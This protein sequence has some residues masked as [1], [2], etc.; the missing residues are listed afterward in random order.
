MTNS[1][2]DTQRIANNP[3]KLPDA[4][5]VHV[6]LPVPLRRLFEYRVPIDSAI[7]VKPGMRVA[8]PFS[9]SE[10][11]GIIVKVCDQPQYTLNKIKSINKV[12]DDSPLVNQS[13]IEL[14][15]WMK[16]Y[17]HAPP[18]EVWQTLLPTALLKGKLCQLKRTSVWK[19]TDEGV[20]AL[21][22][23]KVANNAVKQQQALRILCEN[24]ETGIPHDNLSNFGLSLST[25]KSI[26]GKKWSERVYSP[27]AFS[28]QN[29]PADFNINKPD[30][31]QL[32]S[33]QK[34]A[35]DSVCSAL[36]EFKTS[37]LFGV[38]ASGKTEVYLQIIEQVIKQGKQALVLVPEI[39]LTPQ[40]VERFQRRFNTPIETI[41][42]AMTEQ[43]R[44]QSW[45]KAR[46]G[47]AK[48][49]IGTRSALF[50]PLRN[51]GIIIIDEEHDSSFKQ[52]QGLRYSARDIAM[53]RGNIEKIPV[54]LG[55]ASPSIESLMNVKK[56]K[57]SELTLSKK[58]MTSHPLKYR[59][60]DLKNQPI[61]EG[62]SFALID[63]IKHHLDKQGQILL[64]LNRRGYSPVLLCHNCGW[65]SQCKR[66]D[67]HFTFHSQ[68]THLQCH[69]CGSSKRAPKQC[70]D[71]FG[72]QM[73]P[74]GLGTERLEESIKTIFPAA[75]V[76]RI[77]RDTTRQ[78]SAMQEFVTEIKSGNV[79]IL[80]G[81]QMLAKGHHFPDV[82][83]VGLIDMDGALYSSDFRAP[84]YA[85]QLITQVSGRAGRA[86]KKSEVVIQTH[87]ADHP[88]LGQLISSGYK[89]FSQSTIQQRIEAQLPPHSFNALFQAEATYLGHTKTFLQE[90]KQILQ[91]HKSTT[92]LSSVELLGP[93]PA[94]YTKKA[95]K[96]RYQLYLESNNR[97][98]LHRLLHASLPEVEKLR[99]VSRVRWRM[100][101][102]PIG[103]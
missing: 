100:E 34:I 84:E 37:L 85:A 95:G 29:L 67:T 57:I 13:I 9:R 32:N 61:R 12:L 24:R 90:V 18:G 48:I 103:D 92:H 39:G 28:A 70:P 73:I 83:L 11:I 27:T 30:G 63:S 5:F 97:M 26:S 89:A 99:S 36:D 40:T 54:L 16:N 71:C 55:S 72:D 10:K 74:V 69:H 93:V 59:V 46:S 25:L 4:L 62:L 77:D 76:K 51:P 21:K 87:L 20:N 45:I 17:Y 35:V 96:F 101:V 49:V 58:A 79:D 23:N 78:K 102:D 2:S 82:T 47:E 75:R 60:I 50:V 64:F 98:D 81:T 56:G 66:C 38:T 3:P 52:Q 88:M 94:F 43:Q 1:S 7:E 41:H 68:N 22:T 6:A 65:S 31:L 42:S 19:V 53:V 91:S 86:D 8:V 44:L 33:E 15:E 80:I 14:F